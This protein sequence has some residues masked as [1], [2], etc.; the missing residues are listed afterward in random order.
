MTTFDPRTA[1]RNQGR[2]KSFRENITWEK[3]SEAGVDRVTGLLATIGDFDN[4]ELLT[5]AA[6]L[7]LTSESAA[8]VVWQPVSTGSEPQTVFAPAAGHVLRR[9]SE[10]NEGWV[11]VAFS[12]SRFGHWN[13]ACER[14]VING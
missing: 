8:V 5:L 11:I 3:P 7:A 4:P 10:S 13:C 1:Y 6:G 9:E 14:E 12:R 2:F